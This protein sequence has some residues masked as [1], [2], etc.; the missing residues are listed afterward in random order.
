[1]INDCKIFQ[2]VTHTVFKLLNTVCIVEP[3]LWLHVMISYMPDAHQYYSLTLLGVYSGEIFW[4]YVIFLSQKATSNKHVQ[5]P[6]KMC[7]IY[8][9]R[10]LSK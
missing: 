9:L 1:M 10:Q 6:S 7:L 3:V 2:S 8:D 5:T 4:L